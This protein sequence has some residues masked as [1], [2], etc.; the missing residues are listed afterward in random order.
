MLLHLSLLQDSLCKNKFSSIFLGILVGGLFSVCITSL[1]QRFGFQSSETGT[2]SICYDIGFCVVTPFVSYFATK[3]HR[4]R[5]IGIAI[6]LLGVGS[7]FFAIPHFTTPP[8]IYSNHLNSSKL[9]C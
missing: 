8:Y 2:I 9:N 7:L 5:F 1:E 3:L 4:P 6:I